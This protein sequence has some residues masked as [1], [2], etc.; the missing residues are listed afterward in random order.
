MENKHAS[1]T[2][3]ETPSCVEDRFWVYVN[4]QTGTYPDHTKRGGKW[5]VFVPVETHDD[6][7]QTVKLATECGQLGGIAKAATARPNKNRN[8]NDEK[9]ICVYTYDA[10]DSDDVSKIRERLRELGITQKISYKT[11]QATREGRYA[12]NGHRKIGTRYE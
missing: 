1:E 11:D 10:D 7:W 9:V 6:V 8:S 5:L 2:A 12:V 3:I 4:R